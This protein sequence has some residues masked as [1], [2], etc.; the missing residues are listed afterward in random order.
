MLY[1]E[2]SNRAKGAKISYF[3]LNLL[4]SCVG[5]IEVL[6]AEEPIPHR[7][8]KEHKQTHNGE[9]NNNEYLLLFICIYC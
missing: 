8:F 1:C 9:I 3:S 5:I 4:L 2:L 6:E 7:A